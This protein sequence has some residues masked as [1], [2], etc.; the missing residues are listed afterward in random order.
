MCVRQPDTADREADD[1]D[2]VSETFTDDALDNGLMM[3]V[4]RRIQTFQAIFCVVRLYPTFNA[5]LFRVS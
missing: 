5:T 1:G 4:S 2:M 3:T